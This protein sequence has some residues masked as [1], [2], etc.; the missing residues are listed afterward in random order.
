[1]A[2]GGIGLTVLMEK[3]TRDDDGTI[4]CRRF[5]SCQQGPN[6]SSNNNSSSSSSSSKDNDMHARCPVFDGSLAGGL[7]MASCGE[8]VVS[9]ESLVVTSRNIMITRC[10][11]L[12]RQSSNV[13]SFVLPTNNNPFSSS[14]R[15]ATLCEVLSYADLSGILPFTSDRILA[16]NVGYVLLNVVGR[17]FELIAFCI[18]TEIWLRTAIDARP[19][20]MHSGIASTNFWLH[21]STYVFVF[22]TALVVLASVSLSVVIFCRFPH[23]PNREYVLTMPL[24]MLQTLLEAV[25][26]G[27][28]VGMV[29]LS[30][31]MTSRCVLVLVPSTEWKRRLY[32]LSK[33]VGPMVVSCF[34]YATRCGWL[35][36]AYINQNRRD[37]WAWWISFAWIPTA[38]VSIVLLYSTRKRDY[39]DV[40]AITTATEDNADGTNVHGNSDDNLQQSLLRPQPPEGTYDKY[41]SR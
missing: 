35:I 14:H 12:E 33:A 39:N 8:S 16:E 1:L 15:I 26:W 38:I 22:V 20:S 29:A 36:A 4:L 41:R 19:R 2:L 34:A 25:F 5:R 31:G 40:E 10:M 24:S 37:S 3:T 17:T 18:V 23:A 9:R 27:I 21:W 13:R 11:L 28:H 6:I 7:S 32:L 30:I